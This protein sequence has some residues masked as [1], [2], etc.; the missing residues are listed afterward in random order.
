[1][2]ISIITICF[3]A[4]REIERTVRS[5]LEQSFTDYEY[6]IVDGLSKD[7]TID[8]ANKILADYDSKNVRII[9]EK[10]KGI[11]DA[12][13]KGIRLAGGE[14]INMMNAGDMFADTDV[15]KNIFKNNITNN[16]S[17]LYSDLYKATSYGRIFKVSMHCS[18]HERRIVHQSA[19]Y[20]KRLHWQYGFYVVTPQII[21]SD[22]LFFLQ[23]PI[24]EIQKVDTVIAIY[25]GNGVSEQ[26]NWC[27]Q[28]ILCADVVFRN[29]NFW[30][31]YKD[32]IWWK[33][34]TSLPKRIREKIRLYQAEVYEK[35][36]KTCL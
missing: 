7:H 29:R 36:I 24:E 2:K 35:N 15:L 1:M 3:N 14:W 25:E 34:K 11:Y 6:I 12:M 5:V 16:L 17:F 18:E 30:I 13:N 21:V 23:V 31:I 4:E 10:D 8:V 28:Q 26:G 27:K 9:S 20:R 32:F 22:Y 33:I 19:I